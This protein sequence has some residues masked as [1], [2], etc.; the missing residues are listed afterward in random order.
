M[1]PKDDP[2]HLL[3]TLF[4]ELFQAEQSASLHC[5]REGDRLGDCPLGS[6]MRALGAH[7]T[8]D[9]PRLQTLARER[10]LELTEAG[11]MMGRMFSGV[12]ELVADHVLSAERSYR[13]TVLGVRHGVD[14]MRLVRALAEQLGDRGLQQFCDSWLA[15]RVLLVEDAGHRVRWFAE[16]PSRAQAPS[17]GGGR[18]ILRLVT[19][20]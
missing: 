17:T 6:V 5:R 15:T 9:L 19:S 10:G 18:K 8:A 7:A 2:R 13:M 12:R 11:G 16:H 20:T 14:L 3:H 4:A 1:A